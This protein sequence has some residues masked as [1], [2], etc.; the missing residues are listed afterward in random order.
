MQMNWYEKAVVYHIYPLGY[1]GCDKINTHAEV[2]ENGQ[3]PILRVKEQIPELKRL[4]FNTVFFGPMFES[5]SHGYDTVDYLKVDTRIGT[6]A[7]FAD[8]CRLLHENGI[9]VIVDGVFNHVGRDFVYFAD[10]RKN[11]FNSRYKDWFHIRDGNSNY[12]DGFFYEGWEGHYE[13]VKLNLCNPEV[14]NYIKDAV[15]SWIK[16]YGIDGIRLDVAYCLDL[17]F[18]KELRSHCKSIRNDF[19]LMGETLHGDYNKWMNPEMLDSVTNYECYKGLY[20]SFN[21][22]NMFEIAHSLK[23]QFGQD[24]WCLYKGKKLYCFVDN[25]DVSRIAS[26]LINKKH[27]PLIYTLLFTMPG[28][29]GVYYGSEYGIEG[30]KKNGDDALRPKFELP[31]FGAKFCDELPLHLAKISRAKETYKPLHDGEYREVVLRNKE[32]AFARVSGNETVYT[33]INAG[34]D[35]FSFSLNGTGIYTDVISRE[36]FDVSKPISVKG[37][38]S[39]ILVQNEINFDESV[40]SVETKTE[41]PAETK[42]AVSITV[43]SSES[44][45]TVTSDSSEPAV[46][47]TAVKTAEIANIIEKTKS[48]LR[49]ILNNAVEELDKLK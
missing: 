21:S 10:V 12:N 34:D 5:V 38:K 25:H 39:M 43:V 46:S 30:E 42:S 17:N 32:F 41:T 27:L 6:G 11:K 23:R 35:T 22:L 8:V 26:V 36:K 15:S 4:G 20:S 24:Q 40:K 47:A 3:S 29:P 48:D 28:I 1:L 18:L 16:N 2:Y 13:L 7:D 19:W 14:K 45:I 31:K 9:N 33:L 37:C 44:T 49:R